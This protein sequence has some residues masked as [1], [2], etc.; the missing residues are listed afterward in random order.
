MLRDNISEASITSNFSTLNAISIWYTIRNILVECYALLV[1][2]GGGSGLVVTYT[3]TIPIIKSKNRGGKLRLG[4]ISPLY[5]T[6][7][8]LTVYTWNEF[9]CVQRHHRKQEILQ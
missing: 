7:I 6:I 5:E 2:G 1:R 4:G 9:G 8:I 3:C